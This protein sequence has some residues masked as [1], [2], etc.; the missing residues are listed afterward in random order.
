MF[1]FIGF[2]LGY[3]TEI[4]GLQAPDVLHYTKGA[5]NKLNISNNTMLN[6]VKKDEIIGTWI[7]TLDGNII[8][9]EI[10]DD[11]TLLLDG[12]YSATG[13]WELIEQG[14]YKA[15]YHSM[16]LSSTATMTIKNNN[17]IFN[18]RGHTTLTF[19]KS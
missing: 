1:F 19:R 8:R 14:K 11:N 3:I 10:Y 7:K 2:L 17:L 16:G 6:R 12:M 9:L 4:E 15:K 13:T 5:I 18:E